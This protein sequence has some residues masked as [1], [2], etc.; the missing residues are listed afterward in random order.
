MDQAQKYSYGFNGTQQLLNL[1]NSGNVSMDAVD[2]TFSNLA[3]AM[4]L[5]I[6]GNGMA[7]YSRRAE[8]EV[9]HYA[10]CLQVSWRWVA[11]P[12]LL[13]TGALVLFLLVLPTA[14]RR[15]V[16]PWKS[17]T[18]PTLFHGPA[19]SDWVDADMVDFS[20]TG[21]TARRDTETME[22]MVVFASGI[23]MKMVDQGG[24]Y[25]LRQVALCEEN[26]THL[27]SSKACLDRQ[28][29][30]QQGTIIVGLHRVNRAQPYK[31]GRESTNC[32]K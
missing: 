10:V 7:N 16:A 5:W 14:V 1:Y 12:A 3:Q 26:V 22:G 32:W 20:K 27:P 8:G 4:S 2:A 28:M 24:Q 11:L 31:W 18:L 19:G 13:A 21:K 30:S 29:S 25:K 17:S 15:A 6:R 23:L 9:L